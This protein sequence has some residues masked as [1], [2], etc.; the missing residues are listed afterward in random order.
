MDLSRGD[1]RSRAALTAI[2]VAA[3][4][5]R[6]A[7]VVWLAPPTDRPT[8]YEH[9]EIADNLLAGRGFSVRFLGV[10]GPTSQQAPWVPLL[11]AA[12][13]LPYGHVTPSAVFTLQILQ[14]LAGAALVVAVA[15]TAWGWFPERR[16]IGWAA[17]WA[18]A[19]YPPYV[20]MAT[21]VQ[22][23]PWAALGLA[24]LFALVADERAAARPRTAV[25]FGLTA[26]WLLLVD[27][28]YLLAL[29]FVAWRLLPVSEI[30]L[31]RRLR[32]IGVAATWAALVVAPWLIRNVAVHGEF[33][34]V[35]S[36][37]G[38][39]F[40]Q[41]N[42]ALSWGTDKIPKPT[43]AAAAEAHD[44]SFAGQHRA[45]WEARHETLYIDDVLLK[46]SGYREFTGLSEPD[47]SRL[48]GRRAWRYV[49]EAP[50]E[51]VRRCLRRLHYF[52]LW[53][54]T[55]PKAMSLAY[56]TSSAVWLALSAIGLL[57]ARR[58]WR[59]LAPSMLV[60]C[61][62]T[63]FHVLT[64]TSSRFRIPLESLGLLWGAVGLEPAAANLARHVGR[65]W[66]DARNED[67]PPSAA[68]ETGRGAGLAGPHL[69]QAARHS[70]SI[71]RRR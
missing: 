24:T 36:T 19:L 70:R 44:G 28:I 46:P 63:L 55:N 57:A 15:K 30:T 1:V 48:L 52:L 21:H 41:G 31:F 12:C 3:F 42:N 39:A 7:A 71:L 40:W 8:T 29:P 60:F 62:V 17:G 27:P 18:A 20:Y 14:C 23:A 10:E 51:Y 65:A 5:L 33:V 59:I 11:L 22:A 6:A 13:A 37:F 26:G 54:E 4:A 2:V 49:V 43:V 38:Y 35:K 56:R 69:R 64:I 58:Q 25:L 67:D 53:D 32:P 50:Q 68:T 34:F 47:R 66:R 45:L 61:V 9:G 16:A